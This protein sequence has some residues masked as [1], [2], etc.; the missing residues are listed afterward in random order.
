MCQ[1]FA[2]LFLF[3]SALGYFKLA[4]AHREAD[5]TLATYTEADEVTY[6]PLP[7]A[8]AMNNDANNV[9]VHSNP[10]PAPVT[11]EGAAAAEEEVEE[12]G[13][14]IT[15]E[16]VGTNDGAVVAEGS[17]EVHGLDEQGASD[18]VVKGAA[19]GV[20]RVEGNHAQPILAQPAT[21]TAHRY[22]HAAPAPKDKCNSCCGKL[23]VQHR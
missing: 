21:V 2:S 13:Q 7:G 23:W 19:K 12:E 4:A 3:F 10:N 1:W 16:A 17:G 11:V 14:D 20:Y 8:E 22:A 5:P 18:A 15:F 9:V 6:T